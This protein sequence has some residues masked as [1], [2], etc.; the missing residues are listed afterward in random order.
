M[1]FGVQGKRCVV[2]GLQCESEYN[3]RATEATEAFTPQ[4][5]SLALAVPGCTSS[6][7]ADYGL[8]CFNPN[9]R[10]KIAQKPHILWSL[11]PKAL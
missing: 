11:A 8:E 1:G 6:G 9:I 10:L 4:Q 2:V 3:L 5:S 7:V